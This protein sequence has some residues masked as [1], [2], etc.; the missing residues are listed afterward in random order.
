MSVGHCCPWWLAYTFDN[1]LRRLFQNPEAVVGPYLGEGMT[2]LD[3][4][5]GMGF[6]SIA[7]ARMVGPSGRVISVDLQREMLEIMQKRAGKRGLGGRITPVLCKVD[8]IVA[9]D[10]V[11]FALAMWM[12]HEVP[13][14]GNFFRQVRGCLKDGARFLVAEPR[15]HISRGFVDAEIE[16]AKECGLAVVEEPRVGLSHAVLLKRV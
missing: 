13:D 2:A 11:D 4:G 5:C 12:A 1:A 3:L 16:L 8:D 10:Q 15:F 7:M 14:R 6:Y 9:R